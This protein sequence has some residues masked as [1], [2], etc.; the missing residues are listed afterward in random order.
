MVPALEEG[1]RL[2]LGRA[3]QNILKRVVE[4]HPVQEDLLRAAS[5]CSWAEAV[6]IHHV[7]LG[8][9][10]AVPDPAKIAVAV[11]IAGLVL[12]APVLCCHDHGLLAEPRAARHAV[13]H[14][15]VLYLSNH[16]PT[17]RKVAGSQLTSADSHH[18]VVEALDVDGENSL[19]LL[20]N[21]SLKFQQV[22]P[23]AST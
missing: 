18:I 20:L 6:H 9:S 8:L 17:V 21:D 10:I 23:L 1:E 7:V 15:L 2:E 22:A 4:V 11:H 5:A 12:L 13:R 3:E 19:V 16:Y 14:F